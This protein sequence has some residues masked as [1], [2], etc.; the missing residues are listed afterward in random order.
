VDRVRPPFTDGY[1]RDPALD[2]LVTAF[3]LG[4]H[5]LVRD[6]AEA[7]AKRTDDPRVAAAARD[8]RRRLEPDRLAFVLLGTTA[9]LLLALT[10]W[11]LRQSKI[12][13]QG[14]PPAATTGIKTVQTV[15]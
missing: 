12:H 6:E 9:L 14:R 8:L 1:P 11:A 4:N 5:R 2:R 13:D 10:A 15:K 3:S 7:L